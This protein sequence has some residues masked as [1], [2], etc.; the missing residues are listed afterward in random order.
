MTTT[1]TKLCDRCGEWP[2]DWYIR[3]NDGVVA[4][5]MTATTHM[6]WR[7]HPHDHWPNEAS[8]RCDHCAQALRDYAR[9]P[10]IARTWVWKADEPLEGSD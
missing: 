5:G 2:L 10:Q 1:T 8:D 7:D 9:L 3:D 6:E 4:G